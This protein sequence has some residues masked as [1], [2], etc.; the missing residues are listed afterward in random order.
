MGQSEYISWVKCTSWLSNFVN[1]RGLRQPDGRPL[2]EYHATNDEYTQLTQLLR[3]VGQS[4][5]NICNRDFALM[6]PLMI[7]VK[8]IKLRWIHI[9]SYD[10]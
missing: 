3:A 4:Q 10:Q 8:I 1:L 2:Y 7:L 9:L 6:N 5:S